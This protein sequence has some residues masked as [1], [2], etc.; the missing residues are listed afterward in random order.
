M[1]HLAVATTSLLFRMNFNAPAA[2]V[3]AGS[4]HLQVLFQA[5]VLTF[6]LFNLL[7]LGRFTYEIQHVPTG[8]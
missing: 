3:L 6:Q 2:P 7:H 4:Q 8:A 1:Y 5:R